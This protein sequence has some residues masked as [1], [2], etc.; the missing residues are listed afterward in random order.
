MAAFFT[1]PKA[2]TLFVTVKKASLQATRNMLVLT[3][4]TLNF[5]FVQ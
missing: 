2:Y 5:H 3:T 4:A 1:T